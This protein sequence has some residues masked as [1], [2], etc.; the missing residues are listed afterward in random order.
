M[1]RS[2]CH[3]T[4]FVKDKMSIFWPSSTCIGECSGRFRWMFTYQIRFLA[5]QQSRFT[6]RNPFRLMWYEWNSPSVEFFFT[7]CPILGVPQSTMFAINDWVPVSSC[8]INIQMK[9]NI[10]NV[11]T[12]FHYANYSTAFVSGRFPRFHIPTLNL[13]FVTCSCVLLNN[14]VNMF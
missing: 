13:I 10:I 1:E 2:A 5:V 8:F 3:K 4:C 6:E 12:N 14:L 7:I 11:D 9:T